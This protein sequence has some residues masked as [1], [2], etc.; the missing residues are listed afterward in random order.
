MTIAA[1]IPVAK[2]EYLIELLNVEELYLEKMKDHQSKLL[3]T[4]SVQPSQRE[5]FVK[6][7]KEDYGWE[8]LKRVYINLF[9]KVFTEKEL[10]K[11]LAIYE[12]NESRKLLK[13]FK[14]SEKDLID[15]FFS[16]SERLKKFN[17]KYNINPQLM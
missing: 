3:K 4:Y 16:S 1:D 8:K 13:Y 10:N 14:F 7:Y 15:N 2:V 12:L 9:Q 6:I 17:Q 5:R 11:L